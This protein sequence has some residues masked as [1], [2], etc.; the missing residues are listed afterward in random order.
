MPQFQ[1]PIFWKLWIL[2]KLPNQTWGKKNATLINALIRS[3]F[4]NKNISCQGTFK[5]PH[6]GTVLGPVCG[7]IKG[8][9]RFYNREQNLHLKIPFF[10]RRNLPILVQT[11]PKYAE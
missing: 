10:A 1:G 7:P 9:H 8:K 4:C 6:V 2:A 11:I 5:D 3:I